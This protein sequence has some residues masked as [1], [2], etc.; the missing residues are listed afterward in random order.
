MPGDSLLKRLRNTALFAG[1][2]LS[3]NG[4]YSGE[5][6]Y[7]GRKYPYFEKPTDRY[8]WDNAKYASN[9]YEAHLQGVIGRP[10]EETRGARLRSMDIV[11]QSTGTTLP[12]DWQSVYFE[13]SRIRG[14]HV[15]A[16]LWFGGSTWLA[17]LPYSIADGTGHSVIR[18]CNAFYNTLDW[19][20]N[21]VTEPFCW[22]KGPANATSN[23]Y[24][25]YTSIAH[26]YNKCMMQLN[27]H[28]EEMLHNRRMVLGKSAWQVSGIVDFTAD[29]SDTR[30]GG[31][32]ETEEQRKSRVIYFDL[33][34]TEPLA[35]DD[36]DRHVAGGK[37]FTWQI[38]TAL[39]A[40]MMKGS[41]L[42]V[43]AESL[44]NG[45]KADGGDHSVTYHYETSDSSVLTVDD[46]GN[47]TAVD[48]G[49]ATITVILCENP[50]NRTECTVHIGEN[51]MYPSETLYPGQEAKPY[52]DSEIVTEP[53]LPDEMRM[54]DER[55]V[56]IAK[57][58]EGAEEE[59]V[60][61]LE[62]EGP[63]EYCYSAELN[64]DELYIKCW[65]SSGKPLKLR[66]RTGDTVLEKEIK[67][68]GY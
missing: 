23:E 34:Q 29:F 31:Q 63:D 33:Y 21:I 14:L 68:K 58:R 67:L 1:A 64:G 9:Y 37:A 59:A 3:D 18:R 51:P 38:T 50:A 61:T 49:E 62:T 2:P 66:I 56:R 12:N 47:V 44:R 26:A 20:G 22:Q 32:A 27:E 10:F 46:D 35:T 40:T 45:E 28:T 15:G 54:L 4:K 36:M 55:T 17:A 5:D 52:S 30:E 24:L 13:D 65:E 39:P 60:F 7:T 6:R 42:N 25:D 11:E 8:I 53:E 16:K 48:D 57:Y 41:T 43:N 19:Y